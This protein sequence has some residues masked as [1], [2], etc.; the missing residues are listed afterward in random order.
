[1]PASLLLTK[2]MKLIALAKSPFSTTLQK[3]ASP[4]LKEQRNSTATLR[5]ESTNQK[6]HNETKLLKT[7]EDG[8]WTKERL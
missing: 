7:H 6:L 8:K 2:R 5:K 3:N 1:M 4:F